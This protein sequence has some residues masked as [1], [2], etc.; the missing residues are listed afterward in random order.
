MASRCGLLTASLGVVVAACDGGSS[1]AADGGPPVDAAPLDAAAADAGPAGPCAPGADPTLDEALTCLKRAWCR[2]SS[3]CYFPV[4]EEFCLRHHD[5][6]AAL[7]S[8]RHRRIEPAL[9]EEAV[10]AGVVLYH[11]EEVAPCIAYYD[12]KVCFPGRKDQFLYD[13]CPIFSGTR[14]DGETCLIDPECAGADSFCLNDPACN[15][16]DAC[17]ERTCSPPAGIGE[18]CDWDYI[19]MRC[20]SG[21]RCANHGGDTLCVSG[22]LDTDCVR[23]EECDPGLYCDPV[24]DRCK[25][26]VASGGSCTYIFQCPDDE[27]CIPDSSGESGTCGR[28]DYAGAPCVGPCHGFDCV[29]TGA[30][31]T[32]VP[33]GD[34][35]GADCS[36]VECNILDFSCDYD[37]DQ[38][39]ARPTLGETCDGTCRGNLVCKGGPPANPTGICSEPLIDGEPCQLS[40]HCRSGICDGEPDALT[41]RPYPGCYE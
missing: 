5:F 10:A 6:G 12:Q 20:E 9:I 30:V 32:C 34:E 35:E 4:D 14:A 25:P 17:C 23:D 41:C 18:F 24:S 1:G 8:G 28:V 21:A 37:I 39:V 15:E 19:G 7:N 26:E 29:G 3:R 13:V 40:D 33:Y 31:G 36:E 2:H 38:C 27:Q 16:I 22:D 11:P